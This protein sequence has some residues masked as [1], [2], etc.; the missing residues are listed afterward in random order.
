[1]KFYGQ[2]QAKQ[3]LLQHQK[4]LFGRNGLAYSL[5]KRSLEFFC[6]YFLQNIY[7]G[8]DKAPL[9]PIHYEMWQEC[10]DIIIN[11]TT[12]KQEYILPRGLGKST[13]LTLALSIWCAV[14][15]YKSYIVIASAIGDTAESFIKNIKMALEDNKRIEKAFGKLIDTKRCICNAEKIELTNQTMIQSISASSSF[16]GKSYGNKRIELAILDDFQ[17]SDEIVSDEQRQRKFKRFSDDIN[18]AM[19]KDNST[20]I[21]LGTLQCKDDFYDRLRNSPVFKTK[22][23]KGM[24]VDD[25]Q[26]YFN[27]GL[28]LEFKKI[29]TDKNNEF[30]LDYAKEYYLQNQENMQFPLLWQDYWNCLD[31]ALSYYSNPVSFMQEFQGDINNIGVKKF[32]TIITQSAEQIGD[33]TFIKTILSIDPAGTDRS[34][35]KRDYY[36]FAVV[37]E[38]ENSIKYARKSLIKD[39]EFNDYMAETLD[40]LRKYEDI[41]YINIEKNT[42][43]GSDVIKLKELIEKDDDLRLRNFTFI[44]KSQNQNKDN[45]INAI[46]PEVNL[47][48]VIFNEDDTEPIEQLREFQGCKYT[49]HDDY[50]DCL[51]AAL[52]RLNE[53]EK[54]PKVKVFDLSILGL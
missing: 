16:R 35:T 49:L 10:Q 15:K 11:K 23:E 8:E 5:G 50:P 39:F 51:T 43:S 7:C 21:A 20:I 9:A 31:I 26:E 36:A 4:N 3:L 38:G 29:L 40:L 30:A 14:Y 33:H 22:Q 2:D 47:G 34:G 6:L 53:I 25:V 27:S 52:E 18:Y 28:W 24:L 41:E 32:T 17:K 54:I 37:S 45:R 44:N 46:V 19:Q 12:D 1:M 13:I 48:R 42:Y